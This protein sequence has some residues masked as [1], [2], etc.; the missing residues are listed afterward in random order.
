MNKTK[1]RLIKEKIDEYEKISEKEAEERENEK[2][3]KDYDIMIETNFSDP[4]N[5]KQGNVRVR[6]VHLNIYFEDDAEFESDYIRKK[7]PVRLITFKD[8]SYELGNTRL[9]FWQ[10]YDLLSLINSSSGGK[11]FDNTA[12]LLSEKGDKIFSISPET[13]FKGL[14]DVCKSFEEYILYKALENEFIK[15]RNQSDEI[16]EIIDYNSSFLKNCKYYIEHKEKANK[17]EQPKK[18]GDFWKKKIKSYEIKVK[19]DK[20]IIYEEDPWDPNHPTIK[21]EDDV[22]IE[23]INLKIYFNGDSARLLKFDRFDHSYN[24]GKIKLSKKQF[25]DLLKMI[26][27]EH[28]FDYDNKIKFIESDF[29][30]YMDAE[31]LLEALL[32][33]SEVDADLSIIKLCNNFL[34]ARKKHIKEQEQEIFQQLYEKHKEFDKLYNG[35]RDDNYSDREILTEMFEKNFS[36]NNELLECVNNEILYD[37][38]NAIIPTLEEITKVEFNFNKEDKKE[39][40][41][42]IIAITN[43]KCIKSDEKV[44]PK[45]L[46]TSILG[47]AFSQ[48]AILGKK[49][50]DIY[51][52]AHSI[53]NCDKINKDISEKEA[54]SLIN[55]INKKQKKDEGSHK[56]KKK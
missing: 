43:Y 25:S 53:L 44:S 49:E 50:L 45:S 21:N 32:S 42:S 18:N 8:D 17:N 12:K 3:I 40:I 9:T 16:E 15:Q 55:K 56:I 54:D 39:I 52:V 37:I 28:G 24:T 46:T 29:F 11:I 38:M 31:K 26:T 10:M 1:R 47:E 19:T 13:I 30:D 33:A 22:F 2:K 5:H 20:P 34:N 48:A 23:S 41:N 27:T 36:S 51:D 7:K 14:S 35:L 4:V 6:A